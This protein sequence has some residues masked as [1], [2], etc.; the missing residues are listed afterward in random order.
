MSQAA[1]TFQAVTPKS[2]KIDRKFAKTS[3]STGGRLVKVDRVGG[4]NTQID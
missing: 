1:A 2:D 4:Q 3:R